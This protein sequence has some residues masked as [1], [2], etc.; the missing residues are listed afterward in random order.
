MAVHHAA[1]LDEEGGHL[2]RRHAEG[3]RGYPDGHHG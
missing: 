2:R 3:E 1:L